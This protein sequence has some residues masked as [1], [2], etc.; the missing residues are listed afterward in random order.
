M[1]NIEFEITHEGKSYEISGQCGWEGDVEPQQAP[2]PDCPR[3]KGEGTYL[4]G[5]E[6]PDEWNDEPEEVYD[7]CD[8]WKDVPGT[9]A[10]G[11][12]TFEIDYV[13]GPNGDEL[14]ADEV[15]AFVAAFGHRK[16]ADEAIEYAAACQG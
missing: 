10:V 11:H 8:C 5:V 13:I 9:G 7:G 12:P 2:D 3:C 1:S 15:K 4:V 16:L 14:T 6:P